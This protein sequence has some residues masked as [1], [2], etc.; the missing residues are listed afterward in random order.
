LRIA[1]PSEKWQPFGMKQITIEQLHQETEHWVRQAA[2]NG[3]IMVTDHGQPVAALTQ[4]VSAPRAQWLQQ[5]LAA[6]KSMPAL[7]VDS[8]DV[9]SEDRNR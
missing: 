2:T 3:G 6:L 1:E 4:P 8:A 7:A 5:R 9:I